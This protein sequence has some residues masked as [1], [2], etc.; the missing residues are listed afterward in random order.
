[1]LNI[2]DLTLA[3]GEQIVIEKLNLKI[4][5]NV[6]CG[7]VGINGAGKTTLF[8]GIAAY[9]K[10][11][12]G[13]ITFNDQKCNYDSVAYLETN[14][15]FYPKTTGKEFL[16]LFPDLNSSY[17][18]ELLLQIF[19]LPLKQFID[20]YSTG[21]KKKLAMMAILKKNS[22]LYILDE[23]FNGVDLQT[24]QAFEQIIYRLKEKGK[25]VLI[26]SHIMGPLYNVCDE[27][28]FLEKG[29]IKK[30]YQKDAFDQIESEMLERYNKEVRSIIDKAV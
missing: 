25:T 18:A 27:I 1:M 20:Q 2:Q 12:S 28:C 11:T 10:T 14:N 22:D 6:I 17:N 15:F 24:A 30:Q 29:K 26:S 16:D 3:Y 23:P 5:A 19:K 13:S 8:N 7:I 9:K 21:M 4:Q